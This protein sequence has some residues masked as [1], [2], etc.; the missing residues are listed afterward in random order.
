MTFFSPKIATDSNH[1]S[2]TNPSRQFQEVRFISGGEVDDDVDASV[3]LQVTLP[4]NRTSWLDRTT[5][6]F[7]CAEVKSANNKV[8]T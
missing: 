8:V 1:K 3:T 6:L 7:L 4:K 2:I 5:T